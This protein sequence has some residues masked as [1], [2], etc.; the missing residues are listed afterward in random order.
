MN[1]RWSTPEIREALMKGA[2]DAVNEHGLRDVRVPHILAA[3]GI[4]RRT[5][6]QYFR[7]KDDL[8]LA[9]Y[10]DVCEDL[11]GRIHR[12]VGEAEDA[13]AR[14]FAGVDAYLDFQENGGRLITLLQAEA[15]SPGSP[16]N[17]T[18]ERTLDSIVELL[19]DEVQA[20][21][22]FALHPLAYRALFIAIEGL[23]L[24]LR[25]GGELSSEHRQQ[26]AGVMK[27]MLLRTISGAKY[28]PQAPG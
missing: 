21:T 20:A 12:A 25:E 26:V 14:L 10:E 19:S 6:Y 24:H 4:S 1:E 18:R 5:M 8:M 27:P 3:A 13:A 9:L 23:V 17:P 28:F 22:G 11:L 2:A 15:A 16:L 7:S